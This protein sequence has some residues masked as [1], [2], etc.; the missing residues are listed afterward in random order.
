MVDQMLVQGRDCGDCTECCHA[1]S[2]EAPTLSK[3][4]GIACPN[5][6]AAGCAIYSARPTVCR[7]WYCAWRLSDTLDEAWRPDRS[8][9]IAEILFDEIPEGFALP[10]LRFTL[11][12]STADVHWPPFVDLVTKAL[13]IGQPVYLCLAGPAGHLPAKSLLNVPAFVAAV[14]ADDAQAISRCLTRAG[15][16]LEAHHW[17]RKSAA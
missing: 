8:R 10:A 1:L 9:F 14:E 6:C 7:D 15:Q 11:L 2:I 5:T 3:P 17:E 13:R 4:N 12:R 16:C